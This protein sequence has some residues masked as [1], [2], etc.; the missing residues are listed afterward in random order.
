MAD[1]SLQ[2]VIEAIDK[3]SPALASMQRNL[4]RAGAS[5]QSAGR[6]ITQVGQGLSKFVSLPLAAVAGGFLLAAQ[7]A[8]DFADR[9]TS[10]HDA[11]G[12]STTTLQE[13][14]HAADVAGTS[15]DGVTRG[16]ISLTRR[17]DDI[18]SGVGGGA[19]ELF[20]SLGVSIQDAAGKFRSMEEV[21]PEV[22]TAMGAMRDETERNVIGANLFGLAWQDLAPVVALGAQGIADAR[23]EAHS[24]GLVMS[25]E[26]LKAASDYRVEMANVKAQL[27][28]VMLELGTSLIPLMKDTLLPLLRDNIIPAFRGVAGAVKTAGDAFLGLP[29]PVQNAILVLGGLLL[30]MGPVTAAIGVLTGA[31]GGAMVALAFLAANPIILALAATAGVLGAAF[32]ALKS[33]QAAASDEMERMT[34][35]A[36]FLNATLGLT[37]PLDD[38]KAMAAAVLTWEGNEQ[39]LAAALE[40]VAKPLE[41]VAGKTNAAAQSTLAAAAATAKYLAILKEQSRALDPEA[42]DAFHKANLEAQMMEDI[43]ASGIEITV[44]SESALRQY[45]LALDQQAEFT[46]R[47]KEEQKRLD[48]EWWQAQDARSR[49]ARSASEAFIAA[50][51]RE[52]EAQEKVNAAMSIARGLLEAQRDVSGVTPSD[53]D[54][55]RAQIEAVAPGFQ[56]ANL[57]VSETGSQESRDSLSAILGSLSMSQRAELDNLVLLLGRMEQRAAMARF[58]AAGAPPEGTELRKAW[59]WAVG[60]SAPSVPHFAHGGIVR[61]PTLALVGENGPEEIVP[62]GRGRG[63]R[64]IHTH[65]HVMLDGREIASALGVMAEDEEQVRGS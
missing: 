53:T 11:T 21:F 39:A 64:P 35:R 30:V 36:K 2:V 43:M 3:A 10:L 57:L 33:D 14:S 24:L 31:V 51:R 42:L 9:L 56:A 13:L 16:T 38:Y 6:Q 54:R 61:S 59:D 28:A 19:V 26:G 40:N 22:I 20:Q 41:T 29:E 46:R 34:A 48:E 60:Q 55:I 5:F 18:R 49:A 15:F 17:F 52:Q 63:S 4:E 1:A 7:K 12:L 8:G 27:N 32:L 23:K 62:L 37:I 65:V 47:V 25:A 44:A 50:K 45:N 58:I